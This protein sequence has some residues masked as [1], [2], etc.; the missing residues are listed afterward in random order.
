MFVIK[1]NYRKYYGTANLL[2][3]EI[4]IMV[5][6]S[7][8]DHLKPLLALGQLLFRELSCYSNCQ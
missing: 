4:K 8:G 7:N 1:L 6:N 3:I 2:L 5:L